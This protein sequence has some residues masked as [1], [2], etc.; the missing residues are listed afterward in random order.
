MTRHPTTLNPEARLHT[1]SLHKRAVL[2]LQSKL[3]LTTLDYCRTGILSYSWK[4]SLVYS[5]SL[6]HC[7]SLA[8]SW[9]SLRLPFAS[10]SPAARR[11]APKAC[12]RAS[13]VIRTHGAGMH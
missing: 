3:F 6:V 10:S 11:F 1:H 5:T 12:H 13:L 8:R 4:T 2:H 7:A 9:D